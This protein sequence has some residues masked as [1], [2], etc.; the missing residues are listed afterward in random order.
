MIKWE[1]QEPGWYTSSLG[2]IVQERV[3][4][5]WYLY[6]IADKRVLGPWR[7]LEQ[8]KEAAE[9]HNPAVERYG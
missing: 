3:H 9:K 5:Q 2:G 7:T 1:C 6:P 4:G 8:A